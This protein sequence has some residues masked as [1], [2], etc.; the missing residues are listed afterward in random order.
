MGSTGISGLCQCNGDVVENQDFSGNSNHDHA[1]ENGKLMK[2][3]DFSN[4]KQKEIIVDYVVTPKG[5]REMSNSSVPRVKIGNSNIV[6]IELGEGNY[7]LGPLKDNLFHG[8]GS[9]VMQEETYKGNFIR[10]QKEGKGEL[11]D[12]KGLLIYKGQFSNNYKHGR[13]KL[14]LF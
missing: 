4:I 12:N 1:I 14:S 9:I 11:Y 3:T 5:N 8:N 2:E 13:G 10:G 6:R 7:Y